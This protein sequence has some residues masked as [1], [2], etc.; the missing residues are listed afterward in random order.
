MEYFFILIRK[1]CIF[2]LI[3]LI[4]D[5]SRFCAAGKRYSL[6]FYIG[7]ITHGEVASPFSQ[8]IHFLDGYI[9]VGA[10]AWTMRNFLNGALSMELEGQIGKYFNDQKNWEINLA[11]AARWRKFPW[12][13]KINISVAWGIGPSYATEVPPIEVRINGASRQMLVYW[14]AEATF[15]PPKS[16][17]SWVLRIHHRSPG[18]GLLGTE[19]GANIL[20]SGLKF[21]F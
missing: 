14:F 13:E 1:A 9:F 19:G 3:F 15:G 17:W 11:L 20:S 18:F 12:R 7:Q 2:G 8:N 21:Y 6:T 16:S 5:H 4:L 10:W